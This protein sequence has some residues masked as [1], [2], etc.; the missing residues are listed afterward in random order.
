MSTSSPS[1]NVSNKHSPS[2]TTQKIGHEIN[3]RL[4]HKLLDGW[5]VEIIEVC[6]L[7]SINL[8]TRYTGN[9]GIHAFDILFFI[10]AY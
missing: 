9:P 5:A 4:Y 1:K 10:S 3:V 6:N 8:K 7:Y 2:H